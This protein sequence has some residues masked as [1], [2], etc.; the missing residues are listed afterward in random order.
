MPREL[1]PGAWCLE[2]AIP[3]PALKV[4]NSYAL[5]LS[6]GTLGLIDTGWDDPRSRQS[7]E[8]E[9]AAIGRCVEEISRIAVTH[10]HPDHVGL[11]HQLR[12]ASGAEVFMQEVEQRRLASNVSGPRAYIRE[13]PRVFQRWGV[14]AQDVEEWLRRP[15]QVSDETWDVEAQPLVDGQRL[16]FP[17]WDL[18][19]VWTPGH[20]PGHMCIHDRPGRRLF[21]GDHLLPRITPGV[22]VHPADEAKDPLGDFLDSLE[23]I[24][25]LDADLAHP[26]HEHDFE[27]I[28]SRA[29][30][31]AA[32]HESRLAEIL[33][34][35]RGSPGLTSW[36][37]A[38]NLTWRRPLLESETSNKRLA[39][40]ETQAHL[41]HL[42]RRG[43]IA[44]DDERGM[45]RWTV[46]GR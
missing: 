38:Q 28:A 7:L 18:A 43:L 27:D 9:L 37:T 8:K 12:A 15:S 40:T 30:S 26:A 32:H 10:G 19:V 33:D 16:P 20:S 39:L 22:G 17:G 34:L 3:I 44:P 2:I 21:T 24:E 25:K 6:D 13:A 29:R 42:A 1:S 45:D 5:E 31:L 41:V 23:R 46:A 14:D 4:L 11:A 36:E 35:L